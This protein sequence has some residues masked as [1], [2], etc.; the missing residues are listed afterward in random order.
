MS[1]KGIAH[2]TC[3]S[4]MLDV[5]DALEPAS[6]YESAWLTLGAR[7][8]RARPLFTFSWYECVWIDQLLNVHNIGRN[9]H[10]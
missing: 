5:R 4:A 9:Q 8:H 2:I 1:A 3:L 6:G 10:F 7:D